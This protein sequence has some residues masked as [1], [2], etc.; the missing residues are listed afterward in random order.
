[1]TDPGKEKAGGAAAAI[2]VSVLLVLGLGGLSFWLHGEARK[3]EELLARSKREYRE[4]ADRMKKPIEEAKRR[5]GNRPAPASAEGMD[6]AFLD[7]KRAQAQIPQNLFKLSPGRDKVGGWR[8]THFT[9][10]LHGSKET[11][12]A[13]GPVVDFLAAVENER[14]SVRAKSLNL[15][16]A[17]DH[18]ASAVF[19]LSTFQREEAPAK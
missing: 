15:T 5:G 7:R 2:A 13:R 14:P 3:G 19:T 17:G 8:E 1:M 10:S 6:E 11:P 12:V 16:F 4:M 9:V 18:F